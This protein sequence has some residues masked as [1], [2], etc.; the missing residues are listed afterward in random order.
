[1]N[2]PSR[3][4]LYR[5]HPSVEIPAALRG[6]SL[7]RTAHHEAGH[8]VLMEWCGLTPTGA[9]ATERA[10]LAEWDLTEIDADDDQVAH[11]RPLAAA[12][13]AAVMHAG[14]VA[15]LV[16]AG[17]PWTGVLVRERSQDWKTACLLLSPHFGHGLAGHGYA[18][19]TAHAVVTHHWPRVQQIAAR[20]I[21][22]GKW[23][24]DDGQT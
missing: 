1:M 11:D 4:D 15:E 19:R 10:G 22:T 18:Q 14:I 5:V 8:I 3:A 21:A 17:L 23:S 9:T 2:L 20:L 6:P 13:A 12:Q 16:H 24:P 7:K